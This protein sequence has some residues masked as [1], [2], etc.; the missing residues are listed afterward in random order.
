MAAISK[1]ELEKYYDLKTLK[2]YAEE[3]GFKNLNLEKEEYIDIILNT[4]EYSKLKT[5]N[6]TTAITE[7][8]IEQDL[9]DIETTKVFDVSD[10]VSDYSGVVSDTFNSMDPELY[11]ELLENTEIEYSE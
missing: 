6:D 4:E 1:I 5:K 2:A 8:V 7:S 10:Y 3:L 11:Q 9:A